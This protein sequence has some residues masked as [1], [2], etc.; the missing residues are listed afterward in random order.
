M[1][2]RALISVA[3]LPGVATLLFPWLLLRQTVSVSDVAWLGAIPLTF[4]LALLAWCVVIF[5][6]RGRGTLAPWDPPRRFV[7]TGPYRVVRNP[8]YLGVGS[9]ILGEAV[10]FGSWA[11]AGY[12]LVV[13]ALW[14]LFVVAYEEP[15]LDLQFGAEYRAYKSRVPRW[16]PRGFAVP[17]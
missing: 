7:A 8:M 2:L 16:L 6:S 9:V 11:L 4:G 5:A 10:A 13:A 14:H 1:A 15:A 12:L 3:V 17:R